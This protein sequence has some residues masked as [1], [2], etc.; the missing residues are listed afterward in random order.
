MERTIVVKGVGIRSVR[1]DYTV[2]RFSFSPTSYN[3]QTALEK[4][5]EKIEKLTKRLE[6]A[7]FERY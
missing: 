7:G 1:P 4:A 2:I 5:S 3:Y 6:K